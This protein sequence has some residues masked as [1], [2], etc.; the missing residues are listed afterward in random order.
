MTWY[1]EPLDGSGWP[2][3]VYDHTGTAV[4]SVPE[5]PDGFSVPGDVLQAME[6]EVMAEGLAGGLSERQIAILRDAVFENIEE[7]PPP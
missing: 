5:R 2:I 6:E 7:G 1:Y 3:R 4:K